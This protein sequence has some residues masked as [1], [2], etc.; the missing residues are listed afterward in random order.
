VKVKCTILV[1]SCALTLSCSGSSPTSQPLTSPPATPSTSPAPTATGTPAPGEVGAKSGAKIDSCKVL[2]SDDL[3]SVMGESL[4]EAK[5]S[6][7]ADGGFNVSQCFYAL[8]TFTK[9]VSVSITTAG[10]RNPREFWEQTFHR[11]EEAKKDRKEEKETAPKSERDRARERKK[12]ASKPEKITG[13]GDEA[14]WTS[15]PIVGALYVL[16]KNTFFRIS[17]G[18]ADD[19]KTR[20]NKSKALAAKILSHV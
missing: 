17:I 14:F 7:R 10:T 6:E 12:E 3:K 20:L 11:A 18:G 19:Q 15:S 4:K 16:K 1:V 9:S 13:I 2:S 5:P 8:P